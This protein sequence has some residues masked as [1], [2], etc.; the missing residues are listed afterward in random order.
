LELHVPDDRAG[1]LLAARQELQPELDVSFVLAS[2]PGKVYRGRIAKAALA[3]ELDEKDESTMLVTVDFDKDDVEG[4]RPGGT[5]QARVHC[6]RRSLG[7]V[8]LADLYHY[9]QSLW[10]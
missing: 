3:T 2:E 6:G 8:W 7:Y 10:W 5:A 9:V 4:L 1:A